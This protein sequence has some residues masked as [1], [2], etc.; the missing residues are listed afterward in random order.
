L[1]SWIEPHFAGAE[2]DLA[3]T[4]Q[5]R[6]AALTRAVAPTAIILSLRKLVGKSRT[7]CGALQFLSLDIAEE[8]RCHDSA[9]PRLDTSVDV[10]GRCV[11]SVCPSRPGSKQRQ[12]HGSGST[13]RSGTCFARFVLNGQ[14]QPSSQEPAADRR[15]QAPVAAS[16]RAAEA[17]EAVRCAA[18]PTESSGAQPGRLR[19]GGGPS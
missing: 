6:F 3:P 18:G 5:P 7:R 10:C 19:R 9:W 17:H 2:I 11:S 4:P 14:Q 13:E 1:S 16:G 12:R 15:G 8:K